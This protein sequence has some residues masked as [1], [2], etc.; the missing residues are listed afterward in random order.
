MT[1][2]RAASLV[3]CLALTQP[4]AAAER[5][6]L[7]DVTLTDTARRLVRL[8]SDV[9]GA[10]VVALQFVFT[11]CTAV[12][13]AM[14]AQFGRVQALLAGS[15]FRL[16]S[17][18]ID[19]ETDTPERL[20]A[21]G[22]RFGAGADWILLTGSKD[23]VDRLRKASGVF[24]ADVASHSPTIVVVDGASGRFTRVSGLAPAQAVAEAMT[25]MAQ[26]EAQGAAR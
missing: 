8:R 21:W 23:E 14:G 20:A 3:A 2:G 5:L 16:V 12:C 26:P 24:A 1:A 18:S 19:P 17:V 25:R 22:K 6:E 10:R 13:P 9:I 15:P 11:R 7:P 4:L